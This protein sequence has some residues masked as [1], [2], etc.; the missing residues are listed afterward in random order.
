MNSTGN[1]D[2]I[3]NNVFR[4]VFCYMFSIRCVFVSHDVAPFVGGKVEGPHGVMSA[5]LES[6]VLES[7]HFPWSL[8]ISLTHPSAPTS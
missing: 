5:I 3:I 1:R 7:E 6:R 4:T 8:P 2:N